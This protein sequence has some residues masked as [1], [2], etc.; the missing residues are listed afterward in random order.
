M[1]AHIV[2][3]FEINEYAKVLPHNMMVTRPYVDDEWEKGQFVQPALL[4]TVTDVVP[5]D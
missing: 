1:L 5:I 2:S 4:P 3:S